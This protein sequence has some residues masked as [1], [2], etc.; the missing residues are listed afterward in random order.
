[1]HSLLLFYIAAMPAARILFTTCPKTSL[2][3]CY[4]LPQH[5][6]RV[7]K[8]ILKEMVKMITKFKSIRKKSKVLIAGHGLMQYY[9]LLSPCSHSVAQAKERKFTIFTQ[10]IMQLVYLINQIINL[11]AKNASCLH[12][13]S[14]LSPPAPPTSIKGG[15]DSWHFRLI[16]TS[17]G[18]FNLTDIGL[19]IIILRVAVIDLC[20]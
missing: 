15:G 5:I 6:F 10:T 14:H 16:A 3:S 13:L 2:S 8:I 9:P 12:P 17:N 4:I 18:Y 7:F 11:F 20:F 1:M 19:L